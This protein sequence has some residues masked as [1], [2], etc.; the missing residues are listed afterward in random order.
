VAAVQ[1]LVEVKD[2]TLA[3][4]VQAVVEQTKTNT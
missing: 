3:M 2:T 4:A 1:A